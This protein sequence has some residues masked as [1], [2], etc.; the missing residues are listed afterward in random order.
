LK[1]EKHCYHGNEK[2]RVGFAYISEKFVPLF[3]NYLYQTSEKTLIMFHVSL[4]S[5][6]DRIRCI[7]LHVPL[8]F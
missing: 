5:G 4:L 7:H 6:E 1:H 8:P 2:I 3:L